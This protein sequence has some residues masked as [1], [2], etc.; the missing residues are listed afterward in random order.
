MIGL[1]AL[2]LVLGYVAAL[3]FAASSRATDPLVRRS[4]RCGAF[5]PLG[6][7][8]VVHTAGFAFALVVLLAVTGCGLLAMAAALREREVPDAPP[9]WL[10]PA[11]AFGRHLLAVGQTARARRPPFAPRVRPPRGPAPPPRPE[12]GSSAVALG[13]VRIHA[14]DVIG[15]A[16][17][18]LVA[19]AII[20]LAF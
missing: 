6:V 19:V 18:L 16:I 12:G 1:I 3:A 7:I 20:A 15:G 8:L 13:G 17:G 9:A 4:V 14:T 2:T 10:R 5:L 11:T